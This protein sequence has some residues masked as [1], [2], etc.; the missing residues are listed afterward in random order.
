M[1]NLRK[2]DLYTVLF[3]YYMEKFSAGINSFLGG[4]VYIT[5]LCSVCSSIYIFAVHFCHI[6]IA[7]FSH[8]QPI[9]LIEK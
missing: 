8:L 6:G 7:F 4:P 9:G 1:I 2:A 5:I 3:L